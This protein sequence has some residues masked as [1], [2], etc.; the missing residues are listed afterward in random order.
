[1]ASSPEVL[2][3]GHTYQKSDDNEDEARVANWGVSVFEIP[4]Q[5]PRTLLWSLVRN[6][7]LSSKI[8][9]FIFLFCFATN[10]ST[11]RPKWAI[12][13]GVAEATPVS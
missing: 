11:P 4:P 9:T 3:E 5:S 8:L 2:P 12:F 10:R 7:G 6:F 1:V 13:H